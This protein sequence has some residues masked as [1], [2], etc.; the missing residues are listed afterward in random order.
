MSCIVC[1]ELFG[2]SGKLYSCCPLWDPLSSDDGAEQENAWHHDSYFL[3][4]LF[5]FFAFEGIL[6]NSSYSWKPFQME[7][8]SFTLKDRMIL[9]SIWLGGGLEI[10]ILLVEFY[11]GQY[12]SK[13]S[14]AKKKKDAIKIVDLTKFNPSHKNLI[15]LQFSNAA[16]FYNIWISAFGN[17]FDVNSLQFYDHMTFTITM[18]VW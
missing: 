8:F 2:S 6:F 17:D 11:I 4:R 13:E 16:N 1:L 3:F 7:I 9:Y 18:I 12:N 15:F 14:K 5:S 10:R